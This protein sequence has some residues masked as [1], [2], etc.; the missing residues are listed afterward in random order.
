VLGLDLVAFTNDLM[1][2]AHLPKIRADFTSGV[3]SGVNGTPAFYING[4][5]HDGSWDFASLASALLRAQA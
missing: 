2:H 5:R 1:S 3:M 4:T